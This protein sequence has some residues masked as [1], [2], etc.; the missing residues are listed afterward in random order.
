MFGRYGSAGSVAVT[1]SGTVQGAP[2][3]ETVS[4]DLPDKDQGNSE[5][6]RMWAQKR[7]GRL[8]DSERAGQGSHRQEVVRLSEGYSIVSPYAS[9]L[10]LENDGEYKRWKIQQRNA[11]RIVRDRA[12]RDNVQQRLTKLRRQSAEN[13]KLAGSDR[14]ESKSTPAGTPSPMRQPQPIQVPSRGVDLNIGGGGG[15]AIEPV[16]A[17]ISLGAVGA[18]AWAE[19][20]RKR[21]E[22][23]PKES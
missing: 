20:R 14:P 21:R 6:E 13:F 1:L 3:S 9:M 18:A 23:L 17:C 15:G 10:V 22:T 16:T 5:I 8:L 19:R 12:A 2:W 7:I 11:T 4:M